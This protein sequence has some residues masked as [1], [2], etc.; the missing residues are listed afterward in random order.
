[1][2]RKLAPEVVYRISV[3]LQ[4]GEAVPAIAK[5]I[6]VHYKTVYKTHPSLLLLAELPSDSS[7]E[8]A[9]N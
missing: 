8:S 3:R 4:A 1:M 5:A 9:S 7:C 6:N 2:V